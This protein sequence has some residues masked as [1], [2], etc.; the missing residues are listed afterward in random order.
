MSNQ[1]SPHQPP[2]ASTSPP[3]PAA[4]A[5]GQG[6]GQ[7]RVGG[8]RPARDRC[9]GGL[10]GQVAL[11]GL[12]GCLERVRQTDSVTPQSPRAWLGATESREPPHGHPPP[13]AA[14]IRFL[15]IKRPVF[16]LGKPCQQWSLG[17]RRGGGI[18]GP[19]W[20]WVSLQT[21]P[22]EL[23]RW[24][25]D[26]PGPG[27]GAVCPPWP[28]IGEAGQTRTSATPLLGRQTQHSR[29]IF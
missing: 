24:Q 20:G 26:R 19:G 7:G 23:R 1:R 14:P 16:L 5:C 17:K 21:W 29:Q 25:S 10:R 2:A 12:G 4:S 13:R 11:S 28:G 15:P 22:I 3:G 8:A 6:V 18:R 9:V 27:Q